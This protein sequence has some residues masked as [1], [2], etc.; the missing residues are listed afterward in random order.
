MEASIDCVPSMVTG[1]D[2]IP[3][4]NRLCSVNGAGIDCVPSMGAGIDSETK[5][6]GG[7]DILF[8]INGG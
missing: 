3:S 2:F 6:N 4:I 8:I 7:W 5:I 1:I